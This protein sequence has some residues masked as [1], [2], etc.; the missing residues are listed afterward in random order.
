MKESR[1]KNVLL[2]TASGIA[3]RFLTLL[4]NF[5]L[6]TV[7]IKLLG[8][9]YT[10]VARLFT[11]VLTVL[12]FAEL[13]IGSAVTYALYKPVAENDALQIAKLMNFYKSA[14]RMVAATV[15][16]IGSLLIPF[17]DYLVKDVPDIKEDIRIIY[18]LYLLNTTS[19]YLLI[20][21]S[22]ILD[23]KQKKYIISKIEGAMVLLRL[24][25]QSI[26][27]I[28]F[29][30]FIFYLITEWFMTILK[31]L[32]IARRANAEYDTQLK[33]KLGSKEKK[34]LFMD[35]G[36]LAMYQISSVVLSGTD[37]MI[38]SAV[39]GTSLVGYISYYKLITGQITAIMQQFFWSAN[40][41]V[42]NLAVE[43]KGGG[44]QYELFKS[45]D[46]AVFWLTAF[47]TTCLYV[48]LNPFVEIW[49]GREYQLNQAIVLVLLLDFVVCNFIR[50]VAMFRTANGLFVQGRYRPVIMAGLNIILSIAGAHI[51]GL[52]G[53]LLATVIA[54]VTTQ[55]WY[56]PWLVYKEAFKK[57]VFDYYKRYFCYVITIIISV[58]CAVFLC[59][60]L[61]G[62]NLWIIFSCKAA[63]CIV[64]SNIVIILL[65][66]RTD[67]YKKFGGRMR[68][69]VQLIKS[70]GDGKY[71]R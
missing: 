59:S 51:W 71:G 68:N 3:V 58:A 18:F 23:A 6:Q 52:S 15:F 26:V 54:R 37:S 8:I 11:D 67:E 33:V 10:G 47:C 49:L 5:V 2:G 30:E 1:T 64:V 12:S 32:L 55:M 24:I 7:F 20:Y 39:L 50:V 21:K 60:L 40:A 44:R 46:F 14:Y 62:R 45:I 22:A 38:I 17:L 42:G 13:G 56:D 57:G 9:Q 31:N 65:W 27:L 16:V 53:V 43:D 41:S 63:I 4:F 34:R 35:I 61:Q 19:S 25:L 29:R 66:H 69:I 36:A 48:L 28:I 70:E